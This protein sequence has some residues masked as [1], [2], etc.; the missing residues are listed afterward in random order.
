M[1][2][3]QDA[4][5]TIYQEE[6]HTGFNET[7]QQE[8][9]AFNAA[10]NGA[11]VME[12]DAHRGYYERNAFFKAIASSTIVSRRD[13][14]SVA[15]TTDQ[16]L[17][18][19]EFVGV[20]L[21]RKIGPITQTRGA[22]RRIGMD[23]GEFSILIGQQ[24][25]K[26]QTINMLDAGLLSASIALAQNASVT[27]NVTAASPTDTISTDNLVQLLGKAGDSAGTI[28]LWVMHSTAYYKLV[29]EQIATQSFDAVAGVNIAT[30]TAVT[31]GR[32]VLIT[33]SVSLFSGASPQ[34]PVKVL[35]LREGAITL[36]NSEPP[37]MVISD[38]TDIEQLSIRVHGEFAFTVKLMGYKWDI[39]NGGANPTDTVLGT[40]S[41]WDQAS[42]SFKSLAGVI[43]LADPF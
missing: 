36:K 16:P 43:M 15:A 21:L 41:N 28:R 11:I 23:P 18:E 5:F 27:H 38:V 26:A 20:K 9:D 37:D 39:A 2:I 35:G 33:D 19:D 14:T 40:A 7:L 17:T 10:S 29:R 8:T 42:T 25:A 24:A 13:H 34:S 12:T 4:Q 31:L 22:F 1:A 30:G 6:L 32:P 3:G